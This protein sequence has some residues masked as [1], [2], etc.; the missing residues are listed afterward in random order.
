LSSGDWNVRENDD[1]TTRKM[2]HWNRRHDVFVVRPLQ[3][4]K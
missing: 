2:M 3:L 4:K 1:G